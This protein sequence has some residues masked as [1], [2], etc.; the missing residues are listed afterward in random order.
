MSKCVRDEVK[1][2]ISTKLPQIFI[3][4]LL[5]MLTGCRD[6]SLEEYNSFRKET[7]KFTD[8]LAS[9]TYKVREEY[10][11]KYNDGTESQSAHDIKCTVSNAGSLYERT[12]TKST[13][14]ANAQKAEA[15]WFS[16]PDY[17]ALITIQSDGTYELNTVSVPDI[18]ELEFKYYMHHLDFC[19]PI[20]DIVASGKARVLEFTRGV[21]CGGRD[22]VVVKVA[23]QGPIDREIL[24]TYY[25]DAKYGVCLSF[26]LDLDG[27]SDKK[28]Y[29]E[30]TI[31]YDFTNDKCPV[32]TGRRVVLK[33][34]RGVAERK[35]SYT[36]FMFGPSVNP[37]LFRLSYYDIPEPVLS[38]PSWV[39]TASLLFVASGVAML[40]FLYGRRD[41][42]AL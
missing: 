27:E 2:S 34:D 41:K 31:S 18:S 17:A 12:S 8:A 15:I 26:R 38:K 32:P 13:D 7:S 28:S 22:S 14:D 19:P 3:S 29:H 25:L 11:R 9:I 6:Y 42:P 4:I 30:H 5:S 21:D 37:S 10:N 23:R 20:A 36:D 1:Y 33:A 40:W 24:A 39:Y 35:H 16:N